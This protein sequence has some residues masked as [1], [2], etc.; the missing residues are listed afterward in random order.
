[1]T[2]YEL[3]SEVCIHPNQGN[4]DSW[5][6]FEIAAFYANL[7]VLSF[8]L[9]ES[10][11]W[12]AYQQNLKK[13]GKSAGT[14]TY[15]IQS[16]VIENSLMNHAD[17]NFQGQDDIKI[18]IVND[19]LTSLLNDAATGPNGTNEMSRMNNAEAVN[20]SEAEL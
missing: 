3:Q 16:E 12:G 13:D 2:T 8:Y 6:R 7:L 20:Q 1:M 14:G 11:L 10:R 9:A 18:K 19:E 4:F 17:L 15:S 5:L